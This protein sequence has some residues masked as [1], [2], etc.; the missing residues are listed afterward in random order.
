MDSGV[1]SQLD[2][3][4]RAYLVPFGWKLLGA[5]AALAVAVRSYCENDRNGQVFFETSRVVSEV[6]GDAGFGPRP[7]EMATA[8]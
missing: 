7:G 8:P 4:A 1:T 2:A 6:I 5:A 3:L